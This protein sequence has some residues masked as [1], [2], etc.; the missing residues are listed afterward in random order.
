MSL[1]S[2]LK[3]AIVPDEVTRRVDAIELPW[4]TYGFDPY[5]VSK[6]HLRTF[7][8]MLRYLTR[9]YFSVHTHGIE[10]IPERGRAMLIGNHSGGIAI[11]AS[12]VIAT[13]FFDLPT[14]RLAQGMAEKFIN[15]TPFASQWS[16]RT[17]Q[18]PGLPEHAKRLLEEDRLL[19]V[20]P[21]GARGTAKLYVE[22]HSLVKFG[23]GF[24]RL[25]LETKTPI[26][27]FACLGGGEAMP[28]IANAYELGK[29]VGAPYIPITPYLVP[30]PLP[31]RW[32]VF[33][34][35]PM[36]FEGTG[37]EE[38]EVV[39]KHVESVKERIS[40]MIEAGK[41][42]NRQGKDDAKGSFR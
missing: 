15:Q 41:K 32:D 1:V 23:T 26:I 5:G 29:L 10:N 34:G 33:F 35:A 14:P 20:F 13:M 18:F 4:T 7:F 36:R 27:P 38:D 12:I 17:G 16:S 37:N 22:R 28:T 3:N 9:D 2:M 11:D 40:T 39:Q 42:V 30:V 6:E 24:M 25:A 21:E 8:T 19:L 31:V